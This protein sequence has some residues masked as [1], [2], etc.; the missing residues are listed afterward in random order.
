[1]KNEFKAIAILAGISLLLEGC[2]MVKAPHEEF[3]IIDKAATCEEIRAESTIGEEIKPNGEEDE[4][5]EELAIAEEIKVHK[6]SEDIA[7]VSPP[8][9]ELGDMLEIP[10]EIGARVIVEYPDG[11]VYEFFGEEYDITD[12]SITVFFEKEGF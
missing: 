1:M 5:G 11:E 10:L 7:E 8:Y 6:E 12:N 2:S 4:T 9:I 3:N